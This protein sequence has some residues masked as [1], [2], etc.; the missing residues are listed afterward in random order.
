MLPKI[1]IG[2]NKTDNLSEYYQVIKK[3]DKKALLLQ[4]M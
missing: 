2:S 4:E 1:D 3:I